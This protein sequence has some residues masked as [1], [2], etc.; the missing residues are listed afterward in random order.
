MTKSNVNQQSGFTLIELLIVVAI[1]GILAAVAIPQFRGYQTQAKI[2]AVK[3]NHKAVLNLLTGEFA[4][5]SAGAT[6]ST[7]GTVTTLCTADTDAF[8][9]AVNTYLTGEGM[10]NPYTPSAGAI[11]VGAA[12]T[13]LG[14]TYLTSAPATGVVTVTSV[15]ET[16]STIVGTAVKE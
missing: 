11:T 4:R 7:M 12:G 3:S 5:C 15:D 9:A 16:G 2:N 6:N 1:L 13:T 10:V 14:A 8:S